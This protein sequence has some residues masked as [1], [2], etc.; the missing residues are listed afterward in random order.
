M[1][2]VRLKGVVITAAILAGSILLVT[3]VTFIIGATT[4]MVKLIAQP[5]QTTLVVIPETSHEVR[6]GRGDELTLVLQ[7]PQCPWVNTDNEE[8]G[9]VEV[10]QGDWVNDG[11][12]RI[13]PCKD[14]CCFDHSTQIT[15]RANEPTELHITSITNYNY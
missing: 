15:L 2:N 11:D 12:D 14:Y 10:I 4:M 8:A 13:A 6:L 5:E 1:K 3:I 7:G 9:D